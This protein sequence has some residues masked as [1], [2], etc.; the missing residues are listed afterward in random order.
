MSLFLSSSSLTW[1]PSRTRWRRCPSRVRSPSRCPREWGLPLLH[2][3]L[4]SPTHRWA[5][6]S[7]SSALLR[8]RFSLSFPRQHFGDS[9]LRWLPGSTRSS[10]TTPA[11]AA[12]ASALE[13]LPSQSHVILWLHCVIVKVLLQIN[14]WFVLSFLAVG[15]GQFK[16]SPRRRFYPQSIMFDYLGPKPVFTIPATEMRCFHDRR[17][18][19]DLQ[20]WGLK[21]ENPELRIV[22]DRSR[23]CLAYLIIVTGTTGAARVKISV[24]CK[25]FQIERQK[26]HIWLFWG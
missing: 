5:G 18:R 26:L 23:A 4:T 24:R 13:T 3:L 16:N 19:T 7:R 6:T 8:Q 21:I 22:E 9:L 17:L 10:R 20:N 2:L 15:E 12:S 11:T 1:G 25:F 14:G